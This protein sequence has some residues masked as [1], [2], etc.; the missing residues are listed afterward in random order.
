[1]VQN[2]DFFIGIA[3]IAGIFV[4]FGALI[5]TSRQDE[6]EFS[7]LIRIRGVVTIGLM[8]I[9]AAL[10]PIGFNLY[11]INGHILWFLCSLVFLFLNWTVIIFTLRN[12]KNR[13]LMITQMRTNPVLT[14]FFA[15]VLEVS[16]QVPLILILIGLFPDLEQ[17]LYTTAL[18]FNLF[19]AAFVLVQLVH[20]QAQLK[21]LSK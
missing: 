21:K 17:A 15:L 8:V 9:I 20:S 11:G 6:V 3:H 12:P 16:L 4:G 13:D 1:L 19:E 7:Q 10:L 2:I 5:S 14:A 18:L